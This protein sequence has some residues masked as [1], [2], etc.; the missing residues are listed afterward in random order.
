V[1][2]RTLTLRRHGALLRHDVDPRGAAAAWDKEIQDRVRALDDA[3]IPPAAGRDTIRAALTELWAGTDRKVGSTELLA[4]VASERQ[5]L[6]GLAADSDQL[7]I[8]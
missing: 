2:D 5:P 6:S 1:S 8:P 4:K 7:E 3:G